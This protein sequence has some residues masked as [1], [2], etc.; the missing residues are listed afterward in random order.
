MTTVFQTA[1]LA[2]A[3]RALRANEAKLIVAR[4]VLESAESDGT[5]M[6]IDEEHIAFDFG[7]PIGMTADGMR[8]PLVTRFTIGNDQHLSRKIALVSVGSHAFVFVEAEDGQTYLFTRHW[9]HGTQ[10]AAVFALTIAR[11]VN[12][13]RTDIQKLF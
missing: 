12:A 8:V 6:R 1:D 13:Q 11:V 2:A 5:F 10:L 3:M 4:A 7:R 9:R